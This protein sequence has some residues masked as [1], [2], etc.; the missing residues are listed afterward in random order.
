[1]AKLRV[2]ITDPEKGKKKVMVKTKAP[3]PEE[4]AAANA[5]AK[6]LAIRRGLISGENTHTGGQ[7]PKFYDART[8]ADI[9]GKPDPLVTMGRV[10][11]RVPTYVSSLEWD[12][13]ANLP[14][15]IDEKTGDMKYVAKDLFYLPRFRKNLAQNPLGNL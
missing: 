4:L 13:Q 12:D 11:T 5:M 6:D 10:E 3:T 1:M 15:Y 9:T 2:A 8:G 7:I 14:Y